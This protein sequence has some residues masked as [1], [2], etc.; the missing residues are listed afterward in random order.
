MGNVNTSTQK[1][2]ISGIQSGLRELGLYNGKIDGLFGG[3]GVKALGIVVGKEINGAASYD[4]KDVFYTVQ[5]ALTE[6]GFD[7]KGI[8]GVWG[9]GSQ[10]ALDSAFSAYRVGHRIPSYSYAWSAHPNIPKEA[11]AKIEAWLRKWGKDSNHVSYLLSCMAFETGGTFLPSVQNSKTRATGLIQFMPV[12]ARELGTTIEALA[13]MTFM[14]QLDYVFKYF[15]IYKYIVKCQT[16]EDYYLSIF[17]PA[18]VGKS[19]DEVLA[20][21]GTK[22]YDQNVVFDKERKGYYTVGDICD[23]IIVRYWDGMAPARRLKLN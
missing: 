5:R 10:G 7:T 13:K 16:V 21:R 3:G 1:F 8:D 23:S 14:D 4:A 11:F 15:E 2:A 6:G 19:P 20:S 22:L 12:N 18:R 17:Y 9:K